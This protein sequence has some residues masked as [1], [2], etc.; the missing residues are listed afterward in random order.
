MHFMVSMNSLIK[1]GFSR[2]PF[3]MLDYQWALMLQSAN[4]GLSQ[5]AA[6]LIVTSH[7]S[8]AFVKDQQKTMYKVT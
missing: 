4:F 7:M 6:L 3:I 2:I 1:D 5:C 8:L